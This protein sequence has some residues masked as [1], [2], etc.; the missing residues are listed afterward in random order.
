MLCIR[1][2]NIVD[3][4]SKSP[5]VADI[6][7]ENNKITEIRANISLDTVTTLD[8]TGK[9]VIPGLIDVHCHLR[10]PGFE[11]KE[12][13]LSGMRS[14]AAGGFTTIACMANTNPV[15]DNAPMVEFVKNKA[16]SYGLIRVFP[17][18]AV[19]KG[20]LG[21][22]L[23]DMAELKEAGAI[24][25]SDDGK[26]IMN[27]S[28]MKA[29]LEYSGGLDLLVISHCEDIALSFEGVMNEGEMSTKLG[30]KG[31]NRASEEIMV[32]RDI[33]LSEVTG[34][35]IHIAHISTRGSVELVRQAKLKG[36]KVTCETA[37]HYFSA[38]ERMV[39][40]YDTN[41]KVNPP[42]R[43][44]SDV[45]AVI[46][47]LLDG[48][49]DIIAT[50]HAPH[51]RDEKDVE[52][53]IAANGFSGFELA[54]SL[55]CTSLFKANHVSLGRIV[56]LMSAAPARILGIQGGSIAK[57][58]RADIA[59]VDPDKEFIVDSDK[60]YSKGKNTPFHGRLLNG[61]ILHTI[62]AGK[63]VYSNGKIV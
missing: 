6:L 14:A 2:G 37:P 52:F 9:W 29:A 62:S 36:I 10:E 15:I 48:T 50:D 30:L 47:G 5:Y 55:A 22:E 27:S 42:L 13:I 61:E 11:Y 24:A 54:F 58:S 56:E 20:L 18:A 63:I 45:L 21:Q 43:T 34:T 1:N 3:G 12:D 49:I 59:V 17:I 60:F 39:D 25:V 40:G 4:V 26:P 7:I 28:I 32:A 57:G 46:D 31:I 19:T 44:E 53:A 8:A 38:D 51:H 33:L 23:T 41:A 35:R 16:L